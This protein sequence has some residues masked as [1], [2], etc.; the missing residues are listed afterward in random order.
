MV[1][2]YKDPNGEKIFTQTA[3]NNTIPG[4]PPAHSNT[5]GKSQPPPSAVEE[6]SIVYLLREKIKGLES[7][8]EELT[9]RKKLQL[10]PFSEN[11]I[12]DNSILGIQSVSQ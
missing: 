9:V 3:L 6:G 10:Q 5:M 1:A 12:V 11:C 4:T 2:L 7:H 8:I